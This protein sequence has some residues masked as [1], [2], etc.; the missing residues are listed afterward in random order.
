MSIKINAVSL[1]KLK[2]R[3]YKQQGVSSLL[4]TLFKTFIIYT[5]IFAKN[6]LQ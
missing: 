5:M 1:K 2:I 4:N 3:L 6:V